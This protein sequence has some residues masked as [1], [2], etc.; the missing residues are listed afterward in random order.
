M[1]ETINDKAQRIALALMKRA[2]GNE[3]PLK[4]VQLTE[5]QYPRVQACLYEGLVIELQD[6]RAVEEDVDEEEEAT[7]A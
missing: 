2:F 1:E 3:S 7:G 5:D 4:V 6:D